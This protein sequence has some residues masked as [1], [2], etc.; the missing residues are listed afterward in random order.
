MKAYFGWLLYINPS[1]YGYAGMLRVVLPTIETGCNYQSTIECYPDTGAYWLED[2]GMQ[3]VQPYLS[4]VILLTMTVVAFLVAWAAI[5]IRYASF[6]LGALQ[7]ILTCKRE[8]NRSTYSRVGDDGGEAVDGYCSE[9]DST[10]D[11]DDKLMVP[12][13]AVPSIAISE[14]LE[15]ANY[16]PG[17]G[18]EETDKEHA[19][20]NRRRSTHGSRKSSPKSEET[21]DVFR[22]D[23]PMTNRPN[24][25]SESA[26]PTLDGVR[27]RAARETVRKRDIMKSSMRLFSEMQHSLDTD[28]ENLEAMNHD[29]P[30]RK[31]QRRITM[32]R[33]RGLSDDSEKKWNLQVPTIAEEQVAITTS[34]QFQDVVGAYET[35]L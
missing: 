14:P 21:H 1:Y 20:L 19:V 31:L 24:D 23:G 13:K 18:S 4:L 6:D 29:V 28:V 22:A 30:L 10:S 8:K 15:V 9:S 33:R 5:E 34:G 11:T 2:F 25:S 17:F 7:Y 12:R 32:R 35:A 26:T 27:S 3:D 16:N